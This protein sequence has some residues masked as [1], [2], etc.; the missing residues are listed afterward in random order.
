MNKFLY[1]VIE[2]KLLSKKDY[3]LKQIEVRGLVFKELITIA[4]NN[5]KNW[6]TNA[7]VEYYGSNEVIIL[8][9]LKGEKQPLTI[10]DV[11]DLL[12]LLYFVNILTT[13]EFKL[14]YSVT[15][16]ECKKPILFDVKIDDIKLKESKGVK[17]P[18]YFREKSLEISTL[19]VGELINIDLFFEN[20]KE[21]FKDL[22]I[23]DITTASMIK[24]SDENYLKFFDKLP[25]DGTFKEIE[26]SINI[27]GIFDAKSLKNVLLIIKELQIDFEPTPIKCECSFSGSSKVEITLKDILPVDGLEILDEVRNLH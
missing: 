12:I 15:C 2:P 16:P 10:L 7:I 4:S 27:L 20:K 11:P 14:N 1:R 17:V 3:K 6:N 9:D 18:F 26:K 24:I 25:E 8:T 19:T 23:Q 21:D 22:T 5:T 13:P